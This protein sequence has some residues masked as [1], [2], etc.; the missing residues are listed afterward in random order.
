[1]KKSIFI[2]L[3]L[4]LL[5]S[6]AVATY[7]MNTGKLRSANL[8]QMLPNTPA[9]VLQ[10]DHAGKFLTKFEGNNKMAKALL[11][12][13]AFLPLH[14]QLVF[15]DSLFA[16]KKQWKEK[17]YRGKLFAAVY[18]GKNQILFLLQSP[19]LPH[20][21]AIK[22]YLEN[23]LGKRYIVLYHHAGNFPV[24]AIKIF[25]TTSGKSYWLWKMDGA[26]LFTAQEKIMNASISGYTIREMHF[27]DSPGFKRVAKTSGKLVDARLF[28]YYPMLGQWLSGYAAPSFQNALKRLGR[29]AGWSET[30]VIVHSQDI[31]FSGY[32]DTGK[33]TTLARFSSQQPVNLSAFTLF[34]FNTTFACSGG[35]SDFAN[36]VTP[37]KISA[38]FK[39]AYQ[40]DIEQLVRQIGNDVALVSNALNDKE[41]SGKTWAIVQLKNIPEATRLLNRL[42]LKTGNSR[43]Y[44]RGNHL[45]RRIGI[46]H[47]LPL[48]F[49]QN[50]AR[51]TKNYFCI[52]NGFA[53]FANSPEALTRLI[54]YSETGKTLDLD[55]NYKSFSNHLAGTSNLLLQFSPRAFSGLWHYF[56]SKSGIKALSGY[57]NFLNNVQEVAFQ[58]SHDGAFFYTNF[59]LRYNPAFKNENLALWKVPLSD[60]IVG[61]PFL[62]KDHRSKKY[63]II[64]FDRG[65]RMYLIDPTGKILWTRRLPEL[66]MSS[67]YPIDYYKN[68]KIQYLFNTKNYLFLIDRK[69]NYVA[70]YPIAI[71]PH[72]TNGISVFDYTR[73]KD[74]RILLAQADKRVYNYQINGNEVKGWR[75]P[76]MPALITQQ[77]V[78]LLT[79]RKDYII[80]NDDKN[81]VKIVN[82][83]GQQRI[84]LKAPVNKALHSGYFIN[85]TN[86]KGIILTTNTTGKLVYIAANGK[87]QF[88][89]FGH[90]SAGHYFLYDDF[91]GDGNKDFIFVDKNRL[92]VFDR[93]KKLL[94]SYTFKE[95][96][97]IQ[98]EFFSLGD[99]QRV[100]GIVASKEKTIYLFD[101]KGNIL[102]N[103]GLTGETP[104]TVGSLNNNREVN[105]ITATGNTLYNYRIK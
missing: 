30:D 98:P 49:G 12:T 3:F 11:Q 5:V 51:I 45:I 10:T 55:N 34:P 24:T 38:H 75:K 4:I 36:F 42:A 93:F 50:F 44:R 69:G 79:R 78:R 40:Q 16:A 56:L 74:Y 60:V 90:F 83:R 62:V 39:T 73:Q 53:V 68:R 96:I 41:L 100:L 9:L 20:I 80:I 86:N 22:N 47:F 61:K 35:F 21:E 54:R 88:T 104:F 95:N 15:T 105:I 102:I 94:F 31:V 65:N 57:E 2:Y 84:Y 103:R 72:A 66:P 23:H 89:D 101:N 48:L 33:N 52:I 59:V 71:H 14:K 19:K 99:R 17:F 63:D 13:K 18:P 87:L 46:N 25:N 28:V 26:L 81:H 43:V 77:V 8:W 82:R 85:R 64:V 70:N 32:T 6:V 29:F 58:F 92:K 97:T 27:S 7:F 1:M 76:Q 37:Q 67:I 91:N